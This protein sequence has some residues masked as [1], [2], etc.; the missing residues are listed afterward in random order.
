M[1]CYLMFILLRGVSQ[2]AQVLPYCPS[3]TA[4]YGMHVPLKPSMVWVSS[5]LLQ[6][7]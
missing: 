5:E 7:N 6:L 1:P 2:A 3:C 4:V